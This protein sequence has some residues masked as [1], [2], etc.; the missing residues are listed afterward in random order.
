LC[1]QAK[2]NAAGQE[3][4]G[5]KIRVDYSMTDRAHTP[6]PGVYYGRGGGRGSAGSGSVSGIISVDYIV[7]CNV[8]VIICGANQSLASN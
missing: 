2:E 5:H 6:T 8:S 3:I 1:C 4:D 7:G